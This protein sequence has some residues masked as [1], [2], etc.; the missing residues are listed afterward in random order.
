MN[1]FV[2]T[3][4]DVC[5]H[6]EKKKCLVSNHI[7]GDVSL[8]T[9]TGN[10]PQSEQQDMLESDAHWTESPLRMTSGFVLRFL[11]WRV[12]LMALDGAKQTNLD[13]TGEIGGDDEPQIIASHEFRDLD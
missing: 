5:V 12:R 13:E 2:C 10:V 1:V 4:N 9:I 6:V 3:V 11:Q 7:D 8:P